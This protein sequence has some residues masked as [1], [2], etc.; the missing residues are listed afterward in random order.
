MILKGMKISSLGYPP[1]FQSLFDQQDF[2]LYPHQEEAIEAIKRGENVIVSVPT[3]SGKTLIAY[4]AIFEKFLA[5]QK[6]VYMVPLKALASE[7]FQELKKLR[8]LGLRVKIAVGDYDESPQSIRQSDVVIATSEKLDSMIRHDPSIAYDIGLL[9]ADEVHLIGDQSR[10][11]I[12]EVVLTTI[13]HINPDTTILCLSATMT[14]YEEIATWTNSTAVISD[15]R[16]VPLSKGIIFRNKI[17]REDKTSVSLEKG[18]EIL[19]L[20]SDHVAG[21]GQLLFFVN[22]RK[23]AEELSSSYSKRLRFPLSL[24]SDVDTQEEQ[25]VYDSILEELLSSGYAFHHA[26]LSAKQRNLV[27]TLFRERKVKVLF[28]TPTLAAGVNL[29]ARVVVVRDLTR[30]SDGYSQFISNLEINQMIGRAGRP[31]FDTEGFAYLYAPTEKSLEK[32]WDAL[33]SQPDPIR[34]AL[35][36]EG[37]LRRTSLA[38]IAMGI[39]RNT[40]EL[41]SYYSKTL[42]SF[43]NGNKFFDD[44]IPG[45]IDF[46]IEY[47]FIR[48]SGNSYSAT[49]YGKIVSDLYIDPL[50]AV[51]LREYLSKHYSVDSALYYVCKTADMN[52]IPYRN[53]D[54]SAVE[55]FLDEI[56]EEPTTQEDL[57]SAKTAII[58]K[59]WINETPVRSIEERFLIGYG[60]IQSRVN[61]ADWISYSLSRLSMRFKPEIHVSLENLN[62][63]IKEGVKEDI[64]TLTLIPRIGRVRARRLYQNGFKSIQALADAEPSSIASIYGFSTKL[65]GQVVQHSKRIRKKL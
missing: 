38:L 57:S 59:E 36:T 42:Y 7:K 43:Q 27:E 64:I 24:K 60:D 31:G 14:N 56:N 6:S 39:C 37:L 5:G 47:D 15:F 25:D 2:D 45:A 20:I 54:Y 13:S 28:A 29:P 49:E 63:R 18:E 23:R 19:D 33:E 62:F 52:T 50:S 11:P 58:L 10:G 34:S 46:L 9:V 41:T 12:E 65:A 16:P 48:S 30:F 3:A 8:N 35:G 40:K 4:V 32:S 44:N 26:G 55:D 1:E 53:N 61:T 51:V 17:I 21:G 22:S